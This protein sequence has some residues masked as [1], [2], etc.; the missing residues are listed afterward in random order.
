MKMEDYFILV[1]GV[2]NEKFKNSKINDY[3]LG[4]N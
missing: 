2:T 1:K 4:G 3:R